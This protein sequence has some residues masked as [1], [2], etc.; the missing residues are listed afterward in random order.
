MQCCQNQRV[1]E[2]VFEEV[3][4]IRK[5][6]CRAND[7]GDDELAKEA[8]EVERG[9]PRNNAPGPLVQRGG[10]EFLRHASQAYWGRPRHLT[11][12]PRLI[13]DDHIVFSAV[14]LT[15]ESTKSRDEGCD[16]EDDDAGSGAWGLVGGIH[17]RG[18]ER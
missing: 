12:G 8:D 1:D 11:F 17:G 7:G 5:K 9:Y 16:R 2:K 13:L 10:R 18:K 15:G 14:L 3:G 4:G 6:R